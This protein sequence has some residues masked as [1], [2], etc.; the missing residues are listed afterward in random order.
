MRK[1]LLPILLIGF[2]GF[3]KEQ[4]ENP[5]PFELIIGYWEVTEVV[6]DY[7]QCDSGIGP[8]DQYHENNPSE[9]GYWNYL[10]NADGTWS[11]EKLS[12]S[13]NFYENTG[14][15]NVTGTILSFVTDN[16]SDIWFFDFD[17]NDILNLTDE[18]ECSVSGTIIS[19]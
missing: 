17:G 5:S 7:R 2:W 16:S 12:S 1:Y 11:Y 18:R 15:Y 8:T 6:T 19:S 14:S 3:E 9:T 4:D 13:G 10:M